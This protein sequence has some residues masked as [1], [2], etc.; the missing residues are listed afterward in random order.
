M[1]RKLL[2]HPLHKIA[3]IFMVLLLCSCT[4]PPSGKYVSGGMKKQ[5]G[6]GE[7]SKIMEM[8]VFT[9]KEYITFND[10]GTLLWEKVENGQPISSKGTWTME[11][12]AGEP[13]VLVNFTRTVVINKQEGEHKITYILRKRKNKLGEE[14]LS[15][16]GWKLNDSKQRHVANEKDLWLSAFTK[17]KEEIPAKQ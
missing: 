16:K 13:T 17:V 10:D 7:N 6:K 9:E 12:S 14:E 3:A 4:K 2:N 11:G 1:K 5:V 8:A 15:L